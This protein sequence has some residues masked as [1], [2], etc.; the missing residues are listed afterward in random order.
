MHTSVF[1]CCPR[2]A[3]TCVVDG[4]RVGRRGGGRWRTRGKFS[5][6]EG[7]SGAVSIL[8]EN[9]REKEGRKNSSKYDPHDEQKCWD[10]PRYLPLDSPLRSEERSSRRRYPTA[11]PT[12]TRLGWTG[13][14]LLRCRRNTRILTVERAFLQSESLV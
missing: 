11:D 1:C 9:R 3:T 4:C 6:S 10:E 5:N 7:R 12:V 8:S 2:S 13:P 14:S